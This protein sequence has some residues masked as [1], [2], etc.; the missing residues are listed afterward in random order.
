MDFMNKLKF[1]EGDEYEAAFDKIINGTDG[2]QNAMYNDLNAWDKH[3]R[4]N[5]Q[6][7]DA[8]MWEAAH[9][10]RDTADR[11]R[12]H[13]GLGPMDKTQMSAAP[14]LPF[15]LL[16]GAHPRGRGCR[17]CKAPPHQ[18]DR[19]AAYRSFLS[20]TR[21]GATVLPEAPA[22]AWQATASRH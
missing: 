14:L 16:V 3:N 8:V 6:R 18:R 15:S 11:I 1:S 5:E 21:G 12:E 9:A 22:P 4:L 13:G 10:A 7:R 17:R 20:V 2:A 19:G